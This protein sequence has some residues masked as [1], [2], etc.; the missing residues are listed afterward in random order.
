MRSFTSLLFFL[1][2]AGAA[3]PLLLPQSTNSDS[4]AELLQL[5]ALVTQLQA[6]VEKLESAN[7]AANVE[8]LPAKAPISVQPSTAQIIADQPKNLASLLSGPL[9]GTSVN[10]LFDGYYEYNFNRPIGRANL[11][12][13]YDVSSNSFSINQIGV[14]LENAPNL[15]INKRW[16]ARVDLQWGQATQTLQGNTINES[17]PDLYR[18]LFQAFGTY[19]V[20]VGRGVTVDFGKWASSLGSEGNYTKDQANY[21]RSFWFNYLPYYHAGFRANYRFTDSLALNY[22]VVNGTQE[23]EA[24]NGFKDQMFGLEIAP[25]KR[26]KLTLNYYLGQEHPDV[27][28]YPSG[29]PP[30]APLNLPQLQ[31]IPFQPIR[32]LLT[33]KLH[34]FNNYLALQA[35]PKLSFLLEGNYVISRGALTSAPDHTAGGSLITKYQLTPKFDFAARAE[36]LS[37]RSALFTGGVQA[38]KETTF[39][40]EYRVSDEFS[41]KEEWRR[42]ASNHP[43]FLTD[44]LGILKKEQDTA[45]IGLVWWFGSKTEAW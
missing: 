43:Y 31:G 30:H 16:G 22:W 4:A 39:T 21:S 44:T 33:G 15:D 25:I 40:A 24:N 12:R 10:L 19:I 18:N 20:P 1:I 6:R 36:Y 13:A 26:T 2:L 27:I 37:D 14:V 28:F 42:D 17:R 41:I 3:P 45:T 32:P 7:S 9:A 34:I 35:T 8:A 29:V 11:L 23:T 38:L 5:K